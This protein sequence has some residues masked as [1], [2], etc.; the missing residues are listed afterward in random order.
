METRDGAQAALESISRTRTAIG[1]AG[2]PAWYWLVCAAVLATMPVSTMLPS[3]QD[4][5]AGLVIAVSGVTLAVVSTRVR[6]VRETCQGSF[7][8]RDGLLV[9]GPPWLAILVGA[10]LIRVWW[11]SPLVV[12]A[13]VFAWVATTALVLRRRRATAR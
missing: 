7:P 8:V 3:P 11:W 9:I 10:F 2:Y 5:A 4:M 1:W 13:A 6:G 12:G